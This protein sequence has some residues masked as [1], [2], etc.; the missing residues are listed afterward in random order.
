MIRELD[1][2]I[3][4]AR[5]MSFHR[6]AAYCLFPSNTELFDLNRCRAVLG[7]CGNPGVV[8]FQLGIRR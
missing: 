1:N 7:T 5:A 4:T 8:A 2:P 6:V 3:S